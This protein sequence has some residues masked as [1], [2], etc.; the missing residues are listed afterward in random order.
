MAEDGASAL[1]RAQSFAPDCATVDITLPG[2]S[3]IDLAPRLREAV[4]PRQI[5]LIALTG[6]GDVDMRA[7]CMA[8]G[9][10]AFLVKPGEILELQELLARG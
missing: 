1:V 4:S 6:R 10:D 7:K 3:G 9:F 2:M 8:A 5:F